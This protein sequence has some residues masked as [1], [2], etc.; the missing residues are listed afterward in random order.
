MCKKCEFHFDKLGPLT[1]VKS[2]HEKSSMSID[3]LN[4]CTKFHIFMDNK[5]LNR[6]SNIE[7]KIMKFEVEY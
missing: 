3:T 5:I 7:L 1:I 2:P 6:E 4:K